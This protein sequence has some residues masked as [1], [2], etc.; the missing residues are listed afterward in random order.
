MPRRAASGARPDWEQLQEAASG[1]AGYFTARDALAAGFSLPLLQHHLGAGRLERAQR[2][3]FRLSGFPPTEHE[4]LVPIWLW[5]GREGVFSHETALALH[6]LS[7]ALPAKVHLTVPSAWKKRRLKNPRNLVL[8]H[9][10]LSNDDREW[11][12]AVQ[13]TT[14]LRTVVDCSIDAVAGDLIDQAVRQAVRR[15][16]FTRQEFRQALHRAVRARSDEV[17]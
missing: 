1:Q 6:Q 13:L 11:K 7:D 3:V 15:G 16:D 10:D 9:A 12:G 5:S 2:G 8:H 4:G 17:A 14:P